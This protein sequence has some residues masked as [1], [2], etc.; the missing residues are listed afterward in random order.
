VNALGKYLFGWT[1]AEY[2]A[3]SDAI[4][5]CHLE[6]VVL[7]KLD[8]IFDGRMYLHKQSPNCNSVS[9]PTYIFI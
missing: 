5:R 2:H 6:S 7:V 4:L 1:N 3:A 9:R 8:Q